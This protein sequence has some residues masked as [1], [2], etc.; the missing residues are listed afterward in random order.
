MGTT[1]TNQGLTPFSSDHTTDFNNHI[2]QWDNLGEIRAKNG[3]D[4]VDMFVDPTDGAWN[5]FNDTST[6]DLGITQDDG[7][8]TIVLDN[9]RGGGVLPANEHEIKIMPDSIRFWDGANNQLKV[10]MVGLDSSDANAN[11]VAWFDAANI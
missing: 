7:I 10:Q 3:S 6:V 5:L 1:L 9:E 2:W 4:E 11:N 8:Q